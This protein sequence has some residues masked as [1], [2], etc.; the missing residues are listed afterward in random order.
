MGRIVAIFSSSHSFP[1]PPTTHL[2]THSLLLCKTTLPPYS[3]T[4]SSRYNVPPPTTPND[5]MIA[6]RVLWKPRRSDPWWSGARLLLPGH[7]CFHSNFEAT[8]SGLTLSM[9]TTFLVVDCISTKTTFLSTNKSIPLTNQNP[10]PYLSTLYHASRFSSTGIYMFNMRKNVIPSTKT[11]FLSTNKSIPL[12]YQN[13]PPYLSPLY[14][15][16]RFS[17]TGIYMFNV[18][19]NG[20]HLVHLHFSPF[21]AQVI[22]STKTTF[23]STDKF[24]LHKPKLTSIF[25]HFVSYFKIF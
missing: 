6:A 4:H 25:V 5:T 17:S 7:N 13:P 14:H 21:K 24:T 20:T 15:T 3:T 16:S 9:I 18:R 23:L 12:T 10:H 19:K 1:S 8:Q 2:Q 22:P 11:T